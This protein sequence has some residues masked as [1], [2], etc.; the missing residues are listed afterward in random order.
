MTAS[1]QRDILGRSPIDVHVGERLRLR[2]TLLRMSQ[3]KLATALGLTFQ[4]VQKYERAANRISASRLYQLCRVLKVPISFFFEEMDAEGR[5]AGPFAS[6]KAAPS[7]PVQDDL[8]R[9]PDTIELVEAYY[10]IGSPR[11]RAR[12][13]EFARGLAD[14]EANSKRRGRTRTSRPV[15]TPSTD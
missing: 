11:L 9:Q 6:R 13:L 15:R 14:N 8:L 3:E 1:R 2:R 4:Q 5:K 10:Q 7:A 12:L